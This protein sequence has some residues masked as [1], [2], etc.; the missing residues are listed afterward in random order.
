VLSSEHV[1]ADE[2]ID[3]SNGR[4]GG[5]VSGKRASE[6]RF[7]SNGAGG[8]TTRAHQLASAALDPVQRHALGLLRAV[9]HTA[10]LMR[11]QTHRQWPALPPNGD[12]RYARTVSAGSVRSRGENHCH[13]TSMQHCFIFTPKN[14]I[15]VATY[16]VF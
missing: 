13:Q 14:S 5:G 12:L 15:R 4:S 9:A 2:D 8:T 7:Y 6:D 11:R 10:H 16:C 1:H 3:S